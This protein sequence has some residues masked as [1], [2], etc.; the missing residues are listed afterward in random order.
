MN[1]PCSKECL[2]YPICKHY[3]FI[4][5]KDLLTYFETSRVECTTQ[6]TWKRI[7]EVLPML[8]NI[9]INKTVSYGYS[10]LFDPDKYEHIGKHKFKWYIV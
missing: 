10:P 9:V 2:K 6:L 8:V 5:C 3:R 1:I 4:K 7:H